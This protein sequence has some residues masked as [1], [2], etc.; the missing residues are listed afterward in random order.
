MRCPICN[1]RIDSFNRL[2]IHHIITRGAYGRDRN[3]FDVEGNLITL[4][5]ECHDK[6]HRGRET[7]FNKYGMVDQLNL[8]K[9][10]K[11]DYDI[12]KAG[13]MK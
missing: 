13:R 2:V 8:A 4:C 12:K 5:R 7:F 11:Y 10:L 9:Q 6:V 1:A 3:G